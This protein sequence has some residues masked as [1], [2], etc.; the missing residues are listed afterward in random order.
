MSTIA[1]HVKTH[2]ST[3]DQSAQA[4]TQ[5]LILN[6]ETKP[7]QNPPR[8]MMMEREMTKELKRKNEGKTEKVHLE[9]E[10]GS[11]Y[12]EVC[13][14][15]IHPN[16]TSNYPDCVRNH[17]KSKHHIRDSTETIEDSD[18]S[19]SEDGYIPRFGTPPKKPCRR[20]IDRKAAENALKVVVQYKIPFSAVD[21]DANALIVATTGR[22]VSSSYL[23]NI[24]VPRQVQCNLSV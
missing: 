3:L 4:S 11:L 23:R 21:N 16:Q 7:K 8:E 19:D 12:C 18:E 15:I 2:S 24:E 5:K 6:Q 9:I 14:R 1:S 10:D 20:E 22:S 13:S 17:L